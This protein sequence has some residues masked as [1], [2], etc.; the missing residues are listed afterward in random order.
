MTSR[1]SPL[2]ASQAALYWE[3]SV[4]GNVSDTAH[5][6]PA[7]IMSTR[8]LRPA[9][10][11]S[12]LPSLDEYTV[13]E[14]DT[15]TA[16]AEAYSTDLATLRALNSDVE[17]DYLAPGQSLKVIK[18][19]HGMTYT[20]RDGETLADVAAA[21]GIDADEIRVANG[22]Q[23]DAELPEGETLFLP[24]ARPRSRMVVSRS[25]H[26]RTES[27]QV[28]AAEPKAVPT[29]VAAPAPKPAPKPAPV[30][31]AAPAVAPRPSGDGWKWPIVGGNL[32]SK[33]GWRSDMGDNHTGID[34]AVPAGTPAVA[35]RGGLVE[36]AGWDG[37]YGLCVIIDHGDGTKSRYAHASTLLVSAGQTVAQGQAVIGVGSTGYSTGNHLHFEIIVDGAEQDPLKFLP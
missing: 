36:L 19:F 28:P 2:A 17:P 22:L 18:A 15:L 33:F 29:A 35:V 26:S 3:P 21:Y 12:H 37:G 34:I 24:G 14:G 5:R 32:S 11:E 16:I 6:A 31:A 4:D 27:P 8:L 13:K 10:Q 30:P 1:E 25:G 9:G 7:H 20:A 23:T